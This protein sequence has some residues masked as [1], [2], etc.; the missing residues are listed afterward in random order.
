MVEIFLAKLRGAAS[1]VAVARTGRG[2]AARGAVLAC[3]VC[4]RPRYAGARGRGGGETRP[5]GAAAAPVT[6]HVLTSNCAY[7]TRGGV[8]GTK[9]ARGAAP[10]S[11]S[12]TK[13]S[14]GGLVL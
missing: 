4:T 12:P 14:H 9:T 8:R 11:R 3:R 7:C 10:P 2:L 1:A 6:H 5:P 13:R